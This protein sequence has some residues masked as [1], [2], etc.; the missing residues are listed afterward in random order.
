[1]KTFLTLTMFTIATALFLNFGFYSTNDSEAL[2][3]SGIEMPE[4]IKSVVDNS[5]YM[6]HNL[7]SKN[8]KGKKALAFDNL[9]MQSKIKQIGKFSEIADVVAAGD[10][11]PSK[12]LDHKPEA[13]LTAEQKTTLAK[14]AKG[15]VDKL[16]NNE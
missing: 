8:E 7:E 14:W 6:C 1:M 11:P 3:N 13:K 4:N 9:H 12:F 2:E 16:L 5:C 15:E 10:M